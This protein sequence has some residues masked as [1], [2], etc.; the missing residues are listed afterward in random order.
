MRS[1]PDR[2]ALL[3]LLLLLLLLPRLA[4]LAAAEPQLA[5]TPAASSSHWNLLAAPL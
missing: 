2:P 5:S 4:E 3:R 1:S